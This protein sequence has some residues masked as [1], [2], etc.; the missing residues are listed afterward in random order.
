MPKSMIPT[1]RSPQEDNSFSGNSSRNQRD[2]NPT[3]ATPA[4]W[5]RPQRAPASQD[6]FGR[7]TASGAIADK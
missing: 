2:S 1:S 3:T 5:P 4:E 7:L 6:R